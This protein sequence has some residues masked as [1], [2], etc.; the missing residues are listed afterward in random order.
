MCGRFFFV[1]LADGQIILGLPIKQAGW[2]ASNFA[3]EGEFGAW[4]QTHRRAAVIDVAKPRVPV[5][6]SRVTSLSPTFAGRD[7]TLGG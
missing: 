4:H 6:K 5:P 1:D 2:Q 7:R 3:G